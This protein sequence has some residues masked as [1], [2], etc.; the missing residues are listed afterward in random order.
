MI[1]NLKVILP[2]FLL[3]SLSSCGSD[4]AL[5]K[6]ETF[7]E[8]KIVLGLNTIETHYFINQNVPLTYEAQL[9][10]ASINDSD[11]KQVLSNQAL[12][13]AKSNNNVD[14]DFIH[15]V[16]VFLLNPDDLNDRTEIFFMD[17][18]P[19]GQKDRIQLFSNISDLTQLMNNDKLIVETC[20]EFRQFPPATFDVRLDMDFG[21]FVEE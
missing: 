15:A 9:N 20:L 7:T 13:Y 10:N 19:L 16:N 2:L 8:F 3:L 4:E 11:V 17:A 5:F 18:I 12:L 6:V 14:L 1:K 21:V